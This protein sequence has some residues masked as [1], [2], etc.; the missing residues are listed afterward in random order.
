M[1]L[2]FRFISHKFNYFSIIKFSFSGLH[3]PSDYTMAGKKRAEPT[4]E[5]LSNIEFETSEDVEICQTFDG[6]GLK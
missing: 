1:R 5:D 3:R 2:S 6:M 4:A